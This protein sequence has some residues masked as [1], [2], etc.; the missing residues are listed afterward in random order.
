MKIVFLGTS[1]FA[2]PSLEK[3]HKTHGIAAVVTKQDKPQGRRL[4]SL[5]SPVRS[6]A[7]RLG[8]PSVSI[9]GL[10]EA[11]A[12]SVLESYGADLF[13]VIAYGQIL[14]CKLL[15]LPKMFSVGLHAS[16][17]PKYRGPSP[18]NWAII[19]GEQKTGV[20][21]F[22]LDEKMDSGEIISQRETAILPSDNSETLSE[23]LAA[24][25]AELLSGAVEAIKAGTAVFRKQDPK[26]VT[27]TGKLKK[28]DGMID[29]HKPASE[30]HNRIRGLYG[31]PGAFSAL[32]GKA[33]KI[34]SS[35][36]AKVP[37]SGSPAAPGKITAIDKAGITVS[38]AGDAV[39]I[40]ELQAEGGRRMRASEYALGHKVRPGDSF[41][42]DLH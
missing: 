4:V 12:I 35:E 9:E 18:I 37:A 24:D 23:K 25:G 34:W 8:L 17:L 3:L 41:S 5:P 29:W 21:V 16:M 32:S 7:N 14:S 38:C 26:D 42:N 28:E 33:V 19:N 20:T 36:L 27:V 30:V 10:N 31:W 11:D 40:V 1:G 15:A 39:T 2:V 22:R 13:I 6:A